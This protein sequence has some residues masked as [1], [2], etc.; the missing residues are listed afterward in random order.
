MVW[1]GQNHIFHH[2]LYIYSYIYTHTHTHTHTHVLTHTHTDTHTDTHSHFCLPH[3]LT[4]G[5]PPSV[6]S[7]H[8]SIKEL[9]IKREKEREIERERER[10]SLCGHGIQASKLKML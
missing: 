7:P 4:Q 6:H 2:P 10:E 1:V 5:S 9:E 3:I 8:L